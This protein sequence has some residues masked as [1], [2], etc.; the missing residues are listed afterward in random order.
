M[1]PARQTPASVTSPS[2][3]MGAA[4]P[5][6]APQPSFQPKPPVDANVVRDGILKTLSSTEQTVLTSMLE[7]GEWQ[8]VGNEI[9]VKVAASAALIDM[10]VS[11][12]AKRL[13]IASASGILGRPAKLQILPGGSAQPVQAKA[14]APNGSGRGRAEQEPVVQRMKEKFGAEIRTIIDYRKN[15]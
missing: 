11:S 3:I 1:M 14:S 6:V 2:V 12:E 15:K 9:M 8:L 7:S 5:A 10:S 13:I 4:A